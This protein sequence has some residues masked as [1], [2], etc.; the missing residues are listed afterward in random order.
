MDTFI[1]DLYGTLA[2]IRTDEQSEKF[3]KKFLKSCG[4]LFGAV[5]FF[6]EYFRLME[7]EAK[8]EEY[9][10]PDVIKIFKEIAFIGG[11]KLSDG[12]AE[13]AAK[14]FR[15]L[16]RKKLRLYPHVRGM[17]SRLKK[18]GAALYILS[19]AQSAFTR[20]EIS[21]LKI[22]KYF[23]GIYLSSDFGYKKP[24]Q[25]FFSF[26]IRKNNINLKTAVYIGNDISSDVLGAKGAGL[27]AVYINTAISPAGDSALKAEKE[28]A[29]VVK[30]HSALKKTLL[31]LLK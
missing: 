6:G 28:G 22:G 1:F 19:N 11:K 25:K 15:S 16:S 3:H 10:E 31:G 7:R 20:D 18:S 14:R 30:D 29:Y 13:K 12:E 4:D 9:A 21:S 8:K 26:F 17:L 2:D 27:R 5:D 24:S 23:N